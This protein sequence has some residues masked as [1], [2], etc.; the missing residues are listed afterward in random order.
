MASTSEKGVEYRSLT[1]FTRQFTKIVLGQTMTPT[2]GAAG[3]GF[4]GVG[5]ATS[6]KKYRYIN[7]LLL[8]LWDLRK[9]SILSLLSS[10]GSEISL[11]YELSSLEFLL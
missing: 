9:G 8:F 5:F 2:N 1:N 4:G 6:L 7:L 3:L 10:N 11:L